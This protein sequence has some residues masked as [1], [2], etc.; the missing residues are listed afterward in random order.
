MRNIASCAAC[1]GGPDNKACSPKLNGQPAAYVHAQLQAFASGTRH[2]D[3]SQQMHNIAR[4]MTPPEI[5][6]AARYYANR[7]D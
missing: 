3:I 6:A 2:S 7:M 1:H 5:D 4:Q